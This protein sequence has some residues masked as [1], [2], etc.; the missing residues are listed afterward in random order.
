MKQKAAKPVCLFCVAVPK[1]C[2]LEWHFKQNH[3]EFDSKYPVGSNLHSDF[4]PKEKS[5]L[6][7]LFFF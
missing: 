4:V 5:A 7:R 1:K 6:S 2:N 3:P